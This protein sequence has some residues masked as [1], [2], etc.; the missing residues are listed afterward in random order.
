MNKIKIG[1]L[2]S[3]LVA[4]VV[5]ADATYVKNPDGTVQKVEIV[6]VDQSAE[7]IK[8]QIY[9]NNGRIDSLK[10]QNVEL[11]KELDSLIS[12]KSAQIQP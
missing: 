4:G 7:R 1:I 10:A 6:N 8:S 11:Q 2:I 9:E 3:V 5:F 12:A